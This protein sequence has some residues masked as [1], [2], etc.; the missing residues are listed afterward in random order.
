MAGSWP[1][2]LES[3]NFIPSTFDITALDTSS[4]EFKI[5]LYQLFNSLAIAIN[6]KESGLY[7]GVETINNQLFPAN[8]ALD[9]STPQA[10]QQRPAFRK[11]I[12]FGALPDTSEK[13]VAHGIDFN[14]AS[15]MT[16][17]YATTTNP[18]TSN[19]RPIP[20]VSDDATELIMLRADGTNVY[21]KTFKNQT[22]FTRTFV[23]LE[24]IKQ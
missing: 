1:S 18:T 16:H 12:D 14:A 22:A 5:R 9:S 10:P 4:Q 21:I 11:V 2:G 8:P 15:T 7:Q 6:Q 17:L 24:Y 3:G 13:P 20:F 23:I 19:Y